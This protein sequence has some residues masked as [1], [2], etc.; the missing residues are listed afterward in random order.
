MVEGNGVLTRHDK[1]Y[2]PG[3][4]CSTLIHTCQHH[5][6]TVMGC[7]VTVGLGLTWVWLVLA[8]FSTDILQMYIIINYMLLNYKSLC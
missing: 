1:G 4:F 8:Q 3:K 6:H 2:A 5:T 7:G